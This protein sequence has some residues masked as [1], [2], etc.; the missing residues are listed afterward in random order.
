MTIEADL[1]R[2]AGGKRSDGSPTTAWDDD[3]GRLL[4]ELAATANDPQIQRELRAIN[5]E[6]AATESDGL[7]RM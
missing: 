1:E 3:G 7:G 6:F 2:E 5:S 4:N